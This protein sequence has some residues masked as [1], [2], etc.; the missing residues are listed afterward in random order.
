MFD[1][2]FYE[3]IMH[4]FKC[5]SSVASSSSTFIYSDPLNNKYYNNNKTTNNDDDDDDNV[6][7]LTT[8]FNKQQLKND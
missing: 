8:H 6:N 3:N 2:M 5:R 4:H 1:S 7:I